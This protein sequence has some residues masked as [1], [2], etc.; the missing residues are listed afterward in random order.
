[1]RSV[2]GVVTAGG[3]SSRYGMPKALAEVGGRRVVD[4]ATAALR[5]AL[6]AEDVV[7]IINDPELARAVGLPCRGDV[8]RGIGPLAGVHA[9]LLWARE[10]ADAGVLIVGCD[11]P[12]LEPALLQE[13]VRRRH[14]CD[15]VVP[16]SEGRR[17][18]EP[19]CAYYGT[20]CIA[21]IEAAVTRNDTR[22][23][24]FLDDVRTRRVPLSV[25]RSFGDPTHI[26]LNVNTPHDR[27]VADRLVRGDEP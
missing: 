15:A 19:L 14:G 26:F 7:A 25:V 27:A 23:I 12:F 8:L 4:R 22:M 10:R 24:G 2:L 11:M 17:G 5:T 9:A 3:T 21:A 16:E 18:I 20:A 6:G 1:M 13:L